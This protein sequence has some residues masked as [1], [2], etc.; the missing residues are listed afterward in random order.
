MTA[1]AQDDANFQ[2]LFQLLKTKVTT[3]AYL[4][5]ESNVETRGNN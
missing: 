3:E 1:E 5:V 2:N 4:S